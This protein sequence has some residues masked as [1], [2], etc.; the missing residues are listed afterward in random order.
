VRRIT[1]EVEEYKTKYEIEKEEKEE[2]KKE[3]KKIEKWL[4]ILAAKVHVKLES[5]EESED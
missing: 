2:L 4:T 1:E 5:S 3:V